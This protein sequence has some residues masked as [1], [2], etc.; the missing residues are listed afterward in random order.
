MGLIRSFKYAVRALRSHPLFSV[1]AV[2]SLAIAICAN[3]TVFGV[4]NA[5][6]Y[7]VPAVERPA[8]ISQIEG[9]DS[10]GHMS[11][12]S[13]PDFLYFRGNNS[14]FSGLTAYLFDEQVEIEYA[15]H[16]DIV[17]AT[18]VSGNYFS[19]LGVSPI[20]G[21]GFLPSEDE[22]G[23]SERNSVVVSY[24]CWQHRFGGDP[25][26]I[27]RSVSLNRTS[28]VVV[29]IAPKD[30]TGLVSGFVPEVWIP[31]GDQPSFADDLN[32]ENRSD[33]RYVVLGRLRDGVNQTEAKAQMNVM[34]RQLQAAYPSSESKVHIVF[35]SISTVPSD[36]RPLIVGSSLFLLAVVSICLLIA[37]A[38]LSG[39]LLSR[40]LTK[41]RDFAVRLVLGASRLYLI[42][43]VLTESL[44]IAA[45]AGAL[46]FLLAFW[47]TR[48]LQ[49]LRF[50]M[51]P[52]S[53]DFSPDLRVVA[54][55]TAITLAS[56]LLF[57][58]FP[59][60]VVSGPRLLSFL[61]SGDHTARRGRTG[62]VG[63][64]VIVQ[65]AG[66]LILLTAANVAIQSF[67]RVSRIYPGFSH[68]NVL[69]VTL[70]PKD[71]RHYSD[72]QTRE[73][74]RRLVDRFRL[75]AGIES[76]SLT[77]RLPFDPTPGPSIPLSFPTNSESDNRNAVEAHTVAF[78]AV[79]PG[80]LSTLGIPLIE[81]RE[82]DDDDRQ[83]TP[84]VAIIN[85]IMADRYWP[86]ENPVGKSLNL[87]PPGSS[88]VTIIGVARAGVY[89][90]FR[91]VPRP[92]AYLPVSQQSQVSRITVLVETRGDP[93]SFLPLLQREIDAL[94]PDLPLVMVQ[95]VRE[96]VSVVS[97]LPRVTSG[98]FG[99]FGLLAF[100]LATVGLYS[101][102]EY[103]TAQRTKEFGIR[104]AL[105]ATRSD[106]VRLVLSRGIKL[107]SIGAAFGTLPSF[108]LVLI[109]TKSVFGL[110]AAS[111]FRGM[112]LVCISL[113]AVALIASAIPARKGTGIQPLVALRHE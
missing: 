9:I 62:T 45:L 81:G 100:L 1:I 69:M 70:A 34:A 29:G 77:A 46:G 72:V 14:V 74:L 99:F 24:A 15:D 79:G 63:M 35:S 19:Q 40:L 4:V 37:C 55:T 26:V 7:R 80:Y 56:G 96:Q 53:F 89:D 18:F 87:G 31:F 44:I 20:L 105:G 33:R 23:K 28:F 2:I 42:L 12:F 64:L 66:A 54:F 95:T 6:L 106:I 57:G 78:D 52:F 25:S 90:A 51:V 49:H 67:R 71:T 73:F 10:Q 113:M 39:M 104:V 107:A 93:K 92:Y 47:V 94:D 27:G 8:Q 86:H 21:R 48:V 38:N 13:Y 76:V 61:R 17:F 110:S 16:S 3:T 111:A 88:P 85:N 41:R 109:L 108:L 102:V 5:L 112:A 32:F 43:P 83:A 65:F 75:V 84:R 101:L 97:F 103:T 82:F 91:G 60:W 59:A 58:V 36:I 98:L 50:P 30:F 22:P 11:G 68:S